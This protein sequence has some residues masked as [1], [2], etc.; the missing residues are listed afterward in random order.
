MAFYLRLHARKSKPKK[1]AIF[2]VPQGVG[3]TGSQTGMTKRQYQAANSIVPIILDRNKNIGH[4]GDCIGSD[5]QFHKLM[6]K[7]GA[8]IVIHPPLK[9][10]KRA[11]CKKADLVLK[12]KEYIERNH[13]IV[14][15]TKVLIATPKSKKEEKRSGTW[16]TIRYARKLKRPIY[17]IFPDGKVKLELEQDRQSK[18]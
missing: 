17:F 13:D 16:A 7:S 2:D 4:H 14:D 6:K 9:E 10:N 15:Q 11:F 1:S 18:R 3:T 5:K 8:R 12:P